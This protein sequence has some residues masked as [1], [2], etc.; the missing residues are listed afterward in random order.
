MNTTPILSP[1]PTPAD[2]SPLLSYAYVSAPVRAFPRAELVDLLAISRRNNARIG[3]TGML[4]YKG[5]NFMQALEGPE[6]AVRALQE[7][8]GRDPRHRYMI[9]VMDTWTDERHFGDWMMG[10]RD[11][12]DSAQRPPGYSE[13]LNVPLTGAEF[14]GQASR[15][16]RLLLAFKLRLCRAPWPGE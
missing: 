6:D 4:L 3:V 5:G 9:T 13:F 1:S 11:L 15:A 10:F 2:P 7:R 14:A 8:I 16:Q 12:D